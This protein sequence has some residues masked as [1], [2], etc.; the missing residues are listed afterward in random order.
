MVPI[1]PHFASECLELNKFQLNG[2]WPSYDNKFLIEEKIKYVIQINGRK[3]SLI[4][5][6]RDTDEK[7]LLELVKKEKS[8]SKYFINT[9]IKNIT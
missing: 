4:E 5:F 2:N 9:K 1:I 7:V 8:L 3:R 6:D